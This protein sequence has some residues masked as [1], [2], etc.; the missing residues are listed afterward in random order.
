MTI[1][2]TDK[3]RIAE[4]EQRVTVLENLVRQLQNKVDHLDRN[5]FDPRFCDPSLR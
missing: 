3:Q 1:A 2:T 4:L 5:K